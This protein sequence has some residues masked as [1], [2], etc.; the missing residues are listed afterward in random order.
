MSFIVIML[1]TVMSGARHRYVWV[2][3]TNIHLC[4][5]PYIR[6]YG[7]WT[8]M[9]GSRH[10]CLKPDTYVWAIHTN[11]HLC[12]APYI[13]MYGIWPF[14][15][16]SRHLCLKPDIYVWAIHTTIHLCMTPYIHMYGPYLVC[17]EFDHLCLKPD[18]YVWNQT[19][20]YGAI[21]SYVWS[22]HWYVWNLTI[23][24]WN[25]TIMSETRHICLGHTCMY[26]FYRHICMETTHLCVRSYIYVWA[27]H[28][29][30]SDVEATAKSQANNGVLR[31][32]LR[33]P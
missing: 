19:Y 27:R 16:G 17:M 15:S 20:M 12:V 7:I 11:I 5:A 22:I 10:L 25:Q 2:I 29:G 3:H 8:Y 32:M 33:W 13:R 23:Y 24:V 1:Q 6:M 31:W 4:V 26:D 18:N 30:V 14:M 21:H 28:I 9:S